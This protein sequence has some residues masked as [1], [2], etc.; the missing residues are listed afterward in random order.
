M[1][2]D[3]DTVPTPAK[4]IIS[5][6]DLRVRFSTEEGVV[7]AVNGVDL[8]IKENA[9]LGIMGESGCGKS[10]TA[11][12]IMG[13]AQRIGRVA[14]TIRYT[15]RHGAT[16]DLAT[17]PWQ[18]DEYR[19][20]RGG[21][22]AMIFQE[23]MTSLSPVYTCGN[24]T[25]EVTMLHRGLDEREAREEAV[26]MF[27]RVGIPEAE[28]R[29]DQY[30]FEFSGGMAQR[31]MIAIALS[32]RPRLLIADEPTTALDVTTQ[33]QILKLIKQVRGEF[34]MAM[35]MITHDLGVIAETCEEV[36]TMYRGQIVEFGNTE[37]VFYRHFHPYTV[38]L[39][40]SIPVVSR[41]KVKLKPIEG[42]VPH[43][44]TSIA[45]CQF[46]P[47]C[48]RFMPAKCLDRQPLL[49]VEDGHFARCCLYA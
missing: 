5:T 28:K 22:I 36:A 12:S 17:L 40:R 31:V 42:S 8:D 32:C 37:A 48:E 39:L 33:A 21:D 23:P 18:S 1:V 19:R 35:V 2:H 25:M 30:P 14:G 45:G 4:N 49:E 41:G 7:R 26:E 27:R 20:I 46:H 15:D 44:L 11:L 13:L 29:I 38:G 43:D 16:L 24:Q 47:R 3:R 6:R 10:V 9:T 34:R